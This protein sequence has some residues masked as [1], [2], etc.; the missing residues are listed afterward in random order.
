[1]TRHPLCEQLH[2]N[3]PRTKKIYATIRHENNTVKFRLI[4]IR[5]VRILFE[6]QISFYETSVAGSK[7]WCAVCTG[8]ARPNKPGYCDNSSKLPVRD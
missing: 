8:E 4:S 2:T 1:M 3:E 5:S 6:S 7:G